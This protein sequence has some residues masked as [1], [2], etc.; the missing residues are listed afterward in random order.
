MHAD[1]KVLFDLEKKFWQSIVDEDTDTATSLLT[2]PAFMVSGHGA[3]KFDH[4]RY[5]QMAEQGSM[6][7]KSFELSDMDAIYPTP[8][9]AITQTS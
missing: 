9:A 5:R 4:A 8:E 3:F 1:N 7:V 6:V 2:E